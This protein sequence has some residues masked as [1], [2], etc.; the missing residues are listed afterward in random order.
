[1]I[2]HNVFSGGKCYSCPQSHKKGVTCIVGIIISETGSIFASTSSDGTVYVWELVL[3]STAGSKQVKI[4]DY[5]I[6]INIKI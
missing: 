1:V 3:P 5:V 4:V 2:Q 6:L